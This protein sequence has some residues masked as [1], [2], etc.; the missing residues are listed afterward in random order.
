MYDDWTIADFHATRTSGAGCPGVDDGRHYFAFLD[1][2]VSY[3][4]CIDCGEP[5]GTV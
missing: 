5:E 4:I 3:R 1:H 2:T